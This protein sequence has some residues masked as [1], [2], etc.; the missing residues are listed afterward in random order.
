M[1]C[2]SE[3]RWQ[4]TIPDEF[5]TGFR[6][7]GKEFAV[8]GVAQAARGVPLAS[9]LQSAAT[10][11]K[12]FGCHGSPIYSAYSGRAWLLVAFDVQA[13]ARQSC[14][15]RGD[16]HRNELPGVARLNERLVTAVAI[17]ARK[18][19]GHFCGRLCLLL[20][21]KGHGRCRRQD[22][23]DGGPVQSP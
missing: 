19:D 1:A 23:D 18:V 10:G 12:V 6:A 21:S 2:A 4:A 9:A 5:A 20:L 15:R 13:K 17:K 8:A 14:S 16:A 3:K 22:A 11:Q 7:C